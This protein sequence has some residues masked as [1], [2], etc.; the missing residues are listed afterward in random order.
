MRRRLRT[1]RRRECR[2]FIYRLTLK[3]TEHIKSIH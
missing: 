3:K 1:S 2:L